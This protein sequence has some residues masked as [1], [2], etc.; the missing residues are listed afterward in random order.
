[1]FRSDA[2]SLRFEPADGMLVQAGGQ[3]SVYDARGEY[4][5]IARR[6]RP[7]GEGAM[8]KAFEA[9]KRK[10]AQEGLFDQARKKPIPAMPNSVGIVTSG[11]GAALRDILSVLERRFGGLRVILRPTAVQGRN[12]ASDIAAAIQAFNVHKING[13]SQAVDVLIVGRGGGS[14]EDLWSF[15][16]EIVARAIAASQIPIISAVGHETDVSIADLVADVR[17]PTPSAAAEAAVPDMTTLTH[18]I[19]QLRRRMDLTVKR[20]IDDRRRTIERM[21]ESRGFNQPIVRMQLL[22]QRLD[23]LS[24]RS[25]RAIVARIET[26][27]ATVKSLQSRLKSVDPRG[28][29]NRGFALVESS[30]ERIRSAKSLHVDDTIRIVFSDGTRG[31]IIKD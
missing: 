11:D 5:L 20:A 3:I 13:S 19:E 16:E 26:L 10:L 14:E 6:M 28:P 25:Q 17:A 29:L 2:R 23:D 1:M 12:A 9:V 15:N 7:A 22:S 24:L 27:T 21:V 30:G 8:R 31:A 4:Q 18:R